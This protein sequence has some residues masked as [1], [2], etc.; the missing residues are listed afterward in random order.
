MLGFASPLQLLNGSGAVDLLIAALG[1]A[2]GLGFRHRIVLG[3]QSRRYDASLTDA[4]R[5][6][7]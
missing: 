4:F 5:I 2:F 6:D 3:R 1:L 7:V